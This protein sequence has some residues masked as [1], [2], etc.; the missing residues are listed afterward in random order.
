M[1]KQEIKQDAD[2]NNGAEKQRKTE[3][4]RRNAYDK[5]PWG[6]L[7]CYKKVGKR[8]Y[9]CPRAPCRLSANRFGTHE[10]ILD[11]Y[12]WNEDW[13]DAYYYLQD[14]LQPVRFA[15]PVED[16]KRI[17]ALRHHGKEIE[18]T[19]YPQGCR[20][21]IISNKL[22]SLKRDLVRYKYKYA[23]YEDDEIGEKTKDA[24][25][26]NRSEFID[27]MD[28]FMDT[29]K[30]LAKDEEYTVEREFEYFE[31]LE[32]LYKLA[33]KAHEEGLQAETGIGSHLEQGFVN[34]A[35]GGGLH[36]K[37]GQKNRKRIEKLNEE[38]GNK[39]EIRKEIEEKHK[40][41]KKE[42]EK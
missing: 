6:K 19:D 38:W 8:V 42:G 12:I 21:F 18:L 32:S 35:K 23:G 36:R 37:I 10:R 7:R 24:Y 4:R 30:H 41:G 33:I 39:R 15:C 14:L 16:M 34:A 1:A 28:A 25:R 17:R 2:D 26:S 5:C 11:H 22:K 3:Q 29:L 13:D 20:I 9:I 27:H 40:K 31:H